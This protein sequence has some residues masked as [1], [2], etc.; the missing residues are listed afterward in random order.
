MGKVYLLVRVALFVTSSSGMQ[1]WM[2]VDGWATANVKLI[3]DIKNWINQP[4]TIVFPNSMREVIIFIQPTYYLRTTFYRI[5]LTNTQ[6]SIYLAFTHLFQKFSILIL[7]PTPHSPPF[8]S[9]SRLGYYIHPSF[10]SSSILAFHKLLLLLSHLTL[11]Y[12]CPPCQS[13][14]PN[15]QNHL[16]YPQK[17]IISP[18]LGWFGTG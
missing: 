4:F 1:R 18:V 11:Y 5:N 13:K 6:S 16:S 3:V 2:K 7:L 9:S 14:L 10:N 12:T 8:Q 15:F 17:S